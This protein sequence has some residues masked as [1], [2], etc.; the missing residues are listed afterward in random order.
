M[1][2]MEEALQETLP[3]GGAFLRADDR[4]KTLHSPRRGGSLL[5]DRNEVGV[6]VVSTLENTV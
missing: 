1:N 6:I 2:R 4:M 5:R 3:A